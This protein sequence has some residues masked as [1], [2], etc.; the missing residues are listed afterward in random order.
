MLLIRFVRLNLLKTSCNASHM[1][2]LAVYSQAFRMKYALAEVIQI[3]INKLKDWFWERD[4]PEEIVSK[5]TK[6]ALETSVSGT[7]NKSNKN[8][9]GNSQSGYF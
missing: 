1:K 7:T 5:K 9:E 2:T 4:H 3:N 6:R 8:T